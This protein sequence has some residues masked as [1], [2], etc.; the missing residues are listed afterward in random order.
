MSLNFAARWFENDPAYQVMRVF[1]ALHI[2]DMKGA[3]KTC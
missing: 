3:Q 1:A 2:I